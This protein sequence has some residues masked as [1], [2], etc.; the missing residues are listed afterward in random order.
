MFAVIKDARITIKHK[1]TNNVNGCGNLLPT[2]STNP[3]NRYN[4]D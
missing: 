2:L 3:K 1:I 4:G